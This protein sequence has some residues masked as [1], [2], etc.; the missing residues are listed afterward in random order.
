M[1]ERQ[2]PLVE[3]L[4]LDDAIA[5][6]T[7]LS[8]HIAQQAGI[9]VLVIKG[10][11]AA[12]RGLREPRVSRDV[13]LLVDPD[14]FDDL[15]AAFDQYGWKPRPSADFPILLDLHSRTLVHPKWNC[16]IDVHH[17]WPGF[18][19]DPKDVFEQVWRRRQTMTIAD[20]AVQT[21]GMADS[22]LVLALHSLREAGHTPASNRKML[23]YEY[24]LAQVGQD[25][26]LREA[27]LA[28]A[29]DTDAIQT[30]RPML[31]AL[32]FTIDEERNPSEQLRRWNLNVHARHRMT[33]WVLQLREVPLWQ[34]PGVILRAV[35]PT[36]AE[37]RAIDPMIGA[38][39]M[40]LIAGWWRRFA[41]GVQ[42]MPQ[43]VHDLR[44]HYRSR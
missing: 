23:D 41:R 20:V 38:G 3:G 9:R 34:K 24:L 4:R 12:E 16:D 11:L 21:T 25:G 39:G 14:R 6:S 26:A 1:A 40:A 5:L 15:L 43:A 29:V 37:L 10:P 32:G 35:F 13:D 30:A 42:S 27:V 17:Y 31:T 36:A 44:S 2:A 22:V 19:G 33:G 7:A 28:A 18:L 8:Q